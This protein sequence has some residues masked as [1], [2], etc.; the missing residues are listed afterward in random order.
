MD[1]SVIVPCYKQENTIKQDLKNILTDLDKTR[2]SYEL[3]A[4]VD[5]FL[6]KTYQRAKQIKNPKLRVHGY[7]T[8]KGKGY[9]VRYGM[10]R[11]KGDYIAF[12]DSG[13]DID[14]N[15]ISLIMEHMYWYEADV[16]VGSKR[17]PA[18]KLIYPHRRKFFSIGLQYLQRILFGLKLRD[19]QAGLKVFKREVLEKVL[20]RLII[21]RFAFDIELLVVIKHL[22]YTRIFEAPIKVNWVENSLKTDWGSL[23]KFSWNFFVDMLGIFYRL[24]ILDYYNDKSKRK[25]VYDKEL[26]MR[27]NI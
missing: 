12:I 1:L 8:N 11:A 9:A 23:I 24:N 20:P 21:K 5:G 10:A 7:K 26:D 6:D 25:W 16:I 13:M 18:S 17:H 4:V 19:T 14:P 15:G 22:G 2:F 3:I 27:V